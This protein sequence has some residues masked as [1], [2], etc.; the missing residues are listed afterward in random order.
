[1]DKIVI[2]FSG[3]TMSGVFGAGVATALQDNNIYP[4]VSAVYGSSAGVA[5]G[6]YFLARQSRLGSSIYWEDC[7]KNFISVKNFFIGTWQRFQDEFIKSVPSAH[8][9]DALD[10]EYLMNVV[11]T[12]KRLDTELIISQ[13]IPFYAKLFDLDAGDIAYVDMRRQ[14][15]LDIFATAISPFPYAHKLIKIDGRRYIDAGI[16]DIMGIDAILQ[17]HQNDKILVILNRPG[18]TKLSCKIK[19]TLEGK[20]MQWMFDDR[21]LY[22]LHADAEKKF[23]QD[24]ES[25]SQNPKVIV[26]A[27]PKTALVNSRTI[28]SKNLI[29]A[30]QLGIQAGVHALKTLDLTP[31]ETPKYEDVSE[32][33]KTL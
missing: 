7:I 14:D 29:R 20:F 23:K 13:D 9:R 27:K 33:R 4:R 16:I 18:H 12:K 3:G 11:R 15:I 2:Y 24:L 22:A 30:Y 32:R 5:I 10:I 25:I 26:V 21:R 1:M 17:K 19:N 8:L 28:S 31:T 6:A